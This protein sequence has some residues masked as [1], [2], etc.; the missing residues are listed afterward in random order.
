LLGSGLGYANLLYIATVVLELEKARDYDLLLLLVEEP[1]AHLHP[2]LQTVLLGYLAEQARSSAT[3]AIAAGMRAGRIQVIA[4]THSPHLASSVSTRDVA[5]VRFRERV[6]LDGCNDDGFDLVGE[7]AVAGET[8]KQDDTSVV[9][10]GETATATLSAMALSDAE[11]RK[12]DRYL[13]ATRASLLFARQIILVEGVAEALL[14]RTLAEELVYPASADAETPEDHLNQ[15]RRREFRAITVVPIGGV[16]FMP[17]LKLLF[18]DNLALADR[19][20]VVTDGDGGAGA[21]RKGDIE[22]AFL[23]HIANGC[24]T[25]AVG[26]TTLEA[27]LYAAPSNEDLLREAFRIQHP[28]S[29]A[30]W[31][32]ICSDGVST[33]EER[34]VAFSK[35]LKDGQLD[36]GKGDFAQVVAELIVEHSDKTQFTVPSYLEQAI[37]AAVMARGDEPIAGHVV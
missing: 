12:V 17:Y 34:A 35:A 16:D 5:V 31:D 13:D 1:E 9:I 37:T 28:R 3:N 22:A 36:L 20:V 15:R 18:H 30:K 21:R 32:A 14:L 6:P 10:H 29:L 33:P 24:L 4:T 23:P 11:R 25:V 8:S 19:V 26:E 27:E 7:S 2:Q